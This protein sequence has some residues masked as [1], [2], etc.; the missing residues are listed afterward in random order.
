MQAIYI[1]LV[2][3]YNSIVGCTALF[4]VAYAHQLSLFCMCQLMFVVSPRRSCSSAQVC[5]RIIYMCFPLLSL[6]VYIMEKA[7]AEP[8]AEAEANKTGVKCGPVGWGQIS[9]TWVLPFIHQKV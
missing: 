8:G 2:Y 3:I 9:G 1:V 6:Y 5:V 4:C 7:S